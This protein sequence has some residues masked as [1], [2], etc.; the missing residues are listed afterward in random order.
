MV[1]ALAKCQKAIG[2]GYLSAFPEELFDRLRADER[3]WA[4]FYTLHK[5]LAGMID[6]ATL[7]ANARA[8][9]VAK[10]IASWTARWTQPLGE[11]AMARVLEREYG[12]MNEALYN[13][14][15]L[16][17]DG[18]LR[19][20]A[21]RFDHE[22]IFA[23]LAAEPGRAEGSARQHD[24]PEDRRRGAALGADRGAA[25]PRRRRLLLARGHRRGAPTAPAA[26]A[27]E[28]AGTRRPA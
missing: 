28:R 13:L 25:L 5:I 8:L 10:G 21:H 20:L 2:N 9:D 24:D 27:T 7:A 18:S 4:P 19:E 3:V 11:A 1:D 16:T 22:R 26:R 15:A 12:G 14:G 6:M 17:G 23:P